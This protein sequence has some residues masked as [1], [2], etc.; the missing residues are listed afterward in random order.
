[1]SRRRHTPE[2]IIRK[3]CEGAPLLGERFTIEDVCKHL[4]ISDSTWYCR[5]NRFGTMKSEDAERLEGLEREN[6]RPKRM[7]ADQALDIDML[8]ELNRKSGVA[9]GL[10]FGQFVDLRC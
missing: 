1:M 9:A 7:V 5:P 3:L 6:A 2:Q 10:L 4:E 8:E